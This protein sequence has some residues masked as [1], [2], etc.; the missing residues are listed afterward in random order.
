MRKIVSVGVHQIVD[1]LYPDRRTPLRLYCE[2]RSI[3]NER[4][5]FAPRSDWAIAPYG[6]LGQA[7][8]KNLLRK[9]RYRDLIIINAPAAFIRDR[10]GHGHD[11]WNEHWRSVF[12]D[13]TGVQR[14][15]RNL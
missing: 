7:R 15:A 13:T 2:R 6:G 3:V 12:G 5:S 11:R 4:P 14:P 1:P 10:S 9:L 8:R